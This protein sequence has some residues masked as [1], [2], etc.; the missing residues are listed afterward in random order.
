MKSIDVIM[1]SKVL[2][3]NTSLTEINV[4]YNNLLGSEQFWGPIL[5]TNRL[6]SLTA[7]K[8]ALFQ[9][10]K[11]IVPHLAESTSLRHLDLSFNNF[12]K[13]CCESMTKIVRSHPNLRH[14]DLSFNIGTFDISMNTV[15]EIVQFNTTITYL[16]LNHD[17]RMSYDHFS[18]E[19]D[20]MI[21]SLVKNTTLVTL[22]LN[23]R[24]GKSNRLQMEKILLGNS[25]IT[26]LS[27]APNSYAISFGLLS[28]NKKIWREKSKWSLRVS[29]LARILFSCEEGCLLPN[30][31]LWHI[32]SFVQPSVSSWMLSRSELKRAILFGL[33]RENDM[34]EKKKH[35]YF[36]FEKELANDTRCW[37]TI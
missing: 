34:G 18:P 3:S 2:K 30:E 22:H 36:V 5:A 8:C 11:F 10:T 24:G 17:L 12:S 16:N 26:E 7:T 25:T 20:R 19:L 32:L 13:N 35:Q 6:R 1:L 23:V 28:R 29:C 37:T 14:L 27:L 9:G 21:R 15:H 4:S 31:M 33:E